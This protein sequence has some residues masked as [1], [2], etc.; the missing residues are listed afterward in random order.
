MKIE[1]FDRTQLQNNSHFED[2][3]RSA[4]EGKWNDKMRVFVIKENSTGNFVIFNLTFFERFKRCLLKIFCIDYLRSELLKNK[5]NRKEIQLL[6]SKDIEIEKIVTQ[7]EKVLSKDEK[8]KENNN[9]P[10]AVVASRPMS[11]APNSPMNHSK[12]DD[13][14]TIN[15]PPSK[16]P[17]FS[18]N[19]NQVRNSGENIPNLTVPPSNTPSKAELKK[20]DFEQK[21]Q[22]I[23]KTK[24]NQD[25]HHFIDDVLDQIGKNYLARDGKSAGKSVFIERDKYR[26][27][28]GNHIRT[29][30]DDRKTILDEFVKI[31]LIFAWRQDDRAGNN[32]EVKIEENDT[33]EFE[34]WAR[35]AAKSKGNSSP[36]GD[37]KSN[38][39]QKLELVDKKKYSTHMHDFIDE[40]LKLLLEE[41]LSRNGTDI[42]KVITVHDEKIKIP[43]SISVEDIFA[44]KN[45]IL[46][47]LLKLGIIYS[48]STT[49]RS[50]PLPM[51]KISKEDTIDTL[52]HMNWRTLE[53]IKE[54]EEFKQDPTNQVTLTPEEKIKLKK[55]ITSPI[56]KKYEKQLDKLF[57]GL[58][59]RIK[60]GPYEWK[61]DIAEYFFQP[62]FDQLLEEK[63]IAAYRQTGT[64][65][66]IYV[67]ASDVPLK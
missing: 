49:P 61:T 53:N 41:V 6:S 5:F 32:A 18:A 60:R 37:V 42:G 27:R 15:V 22:L 54:E 35:Q 51:L 55:L 10:A 64:G 30:L 28:Y 11:N 48:W 58:T 59:Q 44:E 66:D 34:G 62:I 2:Q 36:E 38:F 8:E 13:L 52:L 23:D 47:D 39:E 16:T 56:R 45:Q 63:K 14:D 25:M 20:Q 12:L 21:R 65:Y 40:V 31:G 7:G 3:L 29:Y 46:D 19:N 33:C 26:T 24:Y 9:L 67:K 57:F 17:D 4:K 50:T 43:S 1:I